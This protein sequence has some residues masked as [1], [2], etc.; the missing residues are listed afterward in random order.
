MIWT[1]LNWG[2]DVKCSL[3]SEMNWTEL[4]ATELKWL[5]IEKE[6]E[7]KRPETCCKHWYPTYP[8]WSHLPANYTAYYPWALYRSPKS[9]WIMG[10][11][12][13]PATEHHCRAVWQPERTSSYSFHILSLVV[14]LFHPL[15]FLCRVPV[16]LSHSVWLKSALSLDSLY[17]WFQFST[18]LTSLIFLYLI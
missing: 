1:Q 5:W 11:Q 3:T 17:L 16:R 18:S 14:S 10:A 4:N 9:D 8:V 7:K 12:P 15:C 13:L 6:N 2:T